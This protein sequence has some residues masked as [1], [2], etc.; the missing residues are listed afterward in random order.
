MHLQQLDTK[1]SVLQAQQMEILKCRI[2]ELLAA[3]EVAC[4]SLK[5]YKY[6]LD[7]KLALVHWLFLQTR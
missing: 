2:F 4:L 5:I 1:C 7:T 6:I 3:A